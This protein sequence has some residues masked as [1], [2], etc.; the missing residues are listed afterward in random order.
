MSVDKFLDKANIATLQR[1]NNFYSDIISSPLEVVEG[2]EEIVSL[3][4]NSMEITRQ[5]VLFDD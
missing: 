5:Y 3:E 2:A 4:S 1:H